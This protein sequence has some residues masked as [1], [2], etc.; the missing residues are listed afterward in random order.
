MEEPRRP[1]LDA[2]VSEIDA[3]I[4]YAIRLANH[5]LDTPGLDPDSN[6]AVLARQFLRCREKLDA[7]TSALIRSNVD[8]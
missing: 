3:E 8:G 2:A 5:I 7:V 1:I 6:E 4:A